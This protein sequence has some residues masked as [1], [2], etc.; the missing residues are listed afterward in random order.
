MLTVSFRIHFDDD[1]NP[2]FPATPVCSIL[3]YSN[4][5]DAIARHV[6]P[7]DVVKR[8]VLDSRGVLQTINLINETGLYALVLQGDRTLSRNPLTH[9]PSFA[10]VS[11]LPLSLPRFAPFPRLVRFGRLPVCP[12]SQTRS[13]APSEGRA[14]SLREPADGSL[15]WQQAPLSFRRCF[16][17][18]ESDLP[19]PPSERASSLCPWGREFERSILPP[20]A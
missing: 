20:L 6:D 1:G 11:L 17:G 9:T 18:F 12:A 4:S 13:L 3:E 16:D 19:R 8:D 14:R 5:R 7:E 15:A 2:L 10:S